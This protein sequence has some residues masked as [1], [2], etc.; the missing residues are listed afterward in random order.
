MRSDWQTLRL[1]ER[2]EAHFGGK[3]QLTCVTTAAQL[4]ALVRKLASPDW[5]PLTPKAEDP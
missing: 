5:A 1:D 4:P 2:I 3:K